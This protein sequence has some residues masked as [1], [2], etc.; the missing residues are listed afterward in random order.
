MERSLLLVDDEP[1]VLS[2]LKRLL[3]Q[4][5]Y[6]VLTATSSAE[7]LQLLAQHKIKVIISDQRMPHMTG[8]EFLGQ[9]RERWPDTVRI[10]LSG[11][12]DFS[13]VTGAI[14]EGA[15]YKFFTK[16]WDNAQMRANIHEAFRHAELNEK[17]EQL[18]RIFESTLEGIL[19]TDEKGVIQSV[20]PAFTLITG[21][22]AAEAIGQTPAM[23]KSD[24]HDA[25]HFRAMWQALVQNGQ[26]E[27]EIWNRR[28]NGEIYPQW[29]V[30]TA[31]MDNEGN[32][33]QYVGLFNDITEQK[34]NEERIRH[35]AY[36]DAL[37]ELPN[38]LLFNDRLQVA[39]AQARRT[40]EQLAIMFIDLD[41]FKNINDSLGHS[42]GDQLLQ[43]MAQRLLDCTRDEDTVA[44]MGGDEFTVM[45]PR[46]RLLG[47]VDQV[48]R[49]VL[50]GLSKPL[51][52]EGHELVVTASIGI[53]LYP[54][55]GK[56]AEALMKNADSAMYSAKEQ[57]KNKYQFYSADM[58]ASAMEH[59]TLETQ[60]RHA[61]EHE[62]FVLH[63]QP[64]VE[65]NSGR[66]IGFEVL[67]RWQHPELGLVLPGKFITLLEE[68]GLIVPVGEWIL[69]QACRQ[70][71]AWREAGLAP[72]RVAVNFS[73]H[74]FR[75]VPVSQVVAQALKDSDL[76]ADGLE[77]EITEGVLMDDIEQ[78]CET[79]QQLRDMGVAIAI[80]D[81]GTGYSS[82][83]YLKQFPVDM[84][85]IDLSFVRDITCNPQDME[86][87]TSIIAMA[88]GLELGV[89]AEG[90]ETEEQLQLLSEL[91]C[92]Q[93]Q[94][95][96]TGRP[97]AS[98]QATELLLKHSN[99]GRVTS[100]E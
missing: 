93:I 56:Q 15:I 45:L 30:L 57:G 7:G 42:V 95:Y 74:Q 21:Y 67:V 18:T 83:S 26:W 54:D 37:T 8:V 99:K 92:D 73:S 79:L 6:Q 61:L 22:S 23:L 81:F 58:N 100:D 59:F 14:N 19:I 66:L 55:D 65:I 28:K 78:S 88:H 60:L 24:R 13:A 38:R 1:N 41:R 32:P 51:R 40:D 72:V 44:R 34:K 5:G 90:V 4:Q 46:I 29:L 9:V 50:D 36:H 86:I 20:N 63:Y 25:E 31:I 16:P 85:K 62:E 10:V 69:N 71:H 70:N 64:Q 3:R 52:V 68:T 48:A 75:E 91:G 35:Q 89:I 12:A 87:V 11:Y 27:G 80:D 33:S 17:N 96:L 39:L 82:L 97:L 76:S 47:D 84:L 43:G 77:V 49:K 94:G 53:S 98:E 2:A